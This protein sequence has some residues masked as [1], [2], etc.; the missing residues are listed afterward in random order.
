MTKTQFFQF[1]FK[2]VENDNGKL[3]IRGYAST[4]DIDRYNDIVDPKAFENAMKVYMKNPIILLQHNSDK[5]LW[6]VINYTLTL[7]WLEVEVELSNDIENTF[8]L[9][10]NKILKWFSIWYIPKKWEYIVKWDTEIRKIN[11]LDLIE[12]SVVSTPA[13]PNSLFTLAKSIKSFFDESLLNNNETMEIKEVINEEVEKLQDITE[14]AGENPEF[15]EKLWEKEAEVT[16]EV[17]N[18]QNEAV[19]SKALVDM[20]IKSLKDMIENQK[21]EIKT[22]KESFVSKKDFD[23]TFTVLQQIVKT[24]WNLQNIVDKIPQKKWLVALW[25][26]TWE[27]KTNLGAKIDEALKQFTY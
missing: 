18:S 22:L 19:E 14:K 5:P 15:T 24:I 3:K 25:L 16:T 12:I 6:V 4:P 23:D 2:Q 8:N 27:T 21:E 1:E 7:K 9:I 13:N 26:N 11:D 10:N 17:T 20:E